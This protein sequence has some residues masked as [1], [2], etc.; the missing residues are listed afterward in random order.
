MFRAYFNRELLRP[1]LVFERSRRVPKAL[2]ERTQQ[3]WDAAEAAAPVN[4]EAQFSAYRRHLAAPEVLAL[5]K[6]WKRST[7]V[8]YERDAPIADACVALVALLL[9][10]AP[11]WPT[12]R[13]RR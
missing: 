3:L 4:R 13:K 11:P 7:V 8:G 5:L 1:T 6:P 10:K 9:R 2:R 12:R